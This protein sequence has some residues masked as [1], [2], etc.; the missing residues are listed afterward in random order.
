MKR[1][2]F[3][4]AGVIAVLAAVIGINMFA[5]ARL[6]RARLDVT[7]QHLYTLDGGTRQVMA[8]VTGTP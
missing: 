3:S 6:A 4:A 7:E 8:V 2:W 1:F 5:D